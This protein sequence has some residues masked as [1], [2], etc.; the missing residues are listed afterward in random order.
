MRD[1]KAIYLETLRRCAPEMLASRAL[2]HAL[3]NVLDNAADVSPQS[4]DVSLFWEAQWIHVRVRDHGPGICGEILD[5]LGRM[6]VTTKAPGNGNGLGLYLAS[7][8]VT[9]FGGSLALAN[10]EGRGAVVEITLPVCT[11]GQ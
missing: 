6:V 5:V 1:L 2:V 9:Q 10:A 8:A 3:I 7:H 11:G 4:I